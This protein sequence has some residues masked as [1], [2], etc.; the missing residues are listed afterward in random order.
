M[1]DKFKI[2]DVV[3]LKSGSPLM[4]INSL[5]EY[6]NEQ[7]IGETYAECVWFIQKE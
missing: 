5:H 4:T 2:G 1:E 7:D 6:Y 3:Q